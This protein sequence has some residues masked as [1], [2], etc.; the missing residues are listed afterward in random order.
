MKVSGVTKT[1]IFVDC[2]GISLAKIL[3]CDESPLQLEE[4]GQN[5]VAVVGEIRIFIFPEES[6]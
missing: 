2:G 4:T 5:G 1:D 3:V 6:R